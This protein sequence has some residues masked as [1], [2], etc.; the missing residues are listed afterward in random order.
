MATVNSVTARSAKSGTSYQSYAKSRSSSAS[1][2]T[3]PAKKRQEETS[4]DTILTREVILSP[5]RSGTAFATF[6]NQLSPLFDVEMPNGSDVFAFGLRTVQWQLPS[7]VIHQVWGSAVT[8]RR[9]CDLIRRSPV[10]DAIF[11]LLEKGRVHSKCEGRDLD[12]APGDLALLDYTRP[13]ESTASD[14]AHVSLAF[15]RD[16]LPASLRNLHGVKL[17]ADHPSTALLVAHVR[18]LVTAIPHLKMA[19]AEAAISA[20]LT[21]AATAFDAASSDQALTDAR[22]RD[23]AI[24][25]I[26]LRLGDRDLSPG[27]I[28]STIKVSRS[29]LYRLFADQ[30]GIG[31]LVLQLRLEASF[32]ALMDHPRVTGLI[33]E[34]AAR[35]GFKNSSHFSRAFARHFGHTPSKILRLRAKGITAE[36]YTQ[37]LGNDVSMGMDR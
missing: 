12:M 19:V 14:Y 24:A 31:G 11:Y 17:A 23:N 9:S 7:V 1:R 37:N 25:A 30:G 26:K 36:P 29:R 15:S 8:L 33:A 16:V 10:N 21:I 5:D 32:R 27:S 13:L 35:H 20:F 18:A 22:L 6:R 4:H 2:T 28:A 34:V 3:A